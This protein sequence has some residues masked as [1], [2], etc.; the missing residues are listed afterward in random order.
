LQALIRARAS[1]GSSGLFARFYER[2][3]PRVYRH[4]GTVE[5]ALRNVRVA[6]QKIDRE[7]GAGERGYNVKLGRGGIREIEF[8]A[9][10]LQLAYGANDAWLHAP[11]T[12]VS[13]GRLA[14][15]GHVTER[16]R[17]ELSEAYEFLR[18]LEHRLQMEHGLQT[19][20]VPADD[21]RRATVA[22]RM[23]FT[24]DD[25]FTNFDRTLAA[26]TTRVRAAFARVFGEND[27]DDAND[28]GKARTQTPSSE[29]V[30][31][32]RDSHV[33]DVGDT[34]DV[35]TEDAHV[36]RA[37]QHEARDFRAELRAGVDREKNFRAELGALRRAWSRLL[38]EI[39][40]RD[41]ACEIDLA[42]SNRLQ[43]E[44]ATA[45]INAA[46][47]VAR[48]ELARRYGG[49][50]AGPRLSVLALG[51]LA[52][53]GMDYGSDL[54]IVCIF[55]PRVPSP[56]ATLTREQ[57]YAR[58][59]EL[60]TNALSSMT[61]EGHLYRVDLRLRPDGKNGALASSAESFV[62]YVAARTQIWEWLAYVKLR[63]VG[64]DLELGRAVEERARR[65]IHEAARRVDA[66]EL[67]RETRRVR[68]RLE[69]ERGARG[70]HMVD[71][72]Y[73]A[74]GMLDVYFAARYLQLRD[75]VRDAGA[76]RS[77]FSTLARLRDAGSLDAAAFDALREG[78]AAL[79]SLDHAL[80]LVAGRSARL[81]AAPD[82]PL[83]AVLARALH[84]DTTD[85]LI[86][87]VRARMSDVRA[88][89]ERVTG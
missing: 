43:T 30:A 34:H 71:I 67:R 13:L 42:A 52:S 22:R 79:R 21:S 72:K 28:E 37:S 27:A 5:R 15:R 51:R 46:L 40:A 18:A 64:G 14:D 26:H 86:A 38:A 31:D 68:E 39:V 89:Y 61:R 6:K 88:A 76:D 33:A 17:T 74:G 45:S 44:L 23:N 84:F 10:A 41:E 11:H 62:E 12:L 73:G 9:Q 57:F 53:G 20:T 70:S 47:L 60:M 1:A 66:D 69:R 32:A 35:R 63:A 16:E 87:D 8:I 83:V 85:A 77:T 3:R 81:P 55:D 54:D 4:A 56:V 80:R 75:D 82:H 25:A 36:V 2:V 19:H 48:R 78:Y 50:A 29:R 58:L 65:A 49:F 7:Q 59:V 24:G